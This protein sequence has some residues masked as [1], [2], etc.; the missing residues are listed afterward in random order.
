MNCKNVTDVDFCMY[1]CCI[2]PI[3][4]NRALAQRI[5]EILKKGQLNSRDKNEIER[6]K[7]EYFESFEKE[8]KSG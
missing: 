7:S 3:E 1:P 5:F 2:E 6:L 8:G 4:R